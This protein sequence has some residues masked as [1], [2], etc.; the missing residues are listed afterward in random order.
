M[1]ETIIGTIP[2]LLLVFSRVISPDPV[3][4]LV[5]PA[6]ISV[7]VWVIAVLVV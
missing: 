3:V 2:K 7:P 1:L 4:K 6:M 5:E